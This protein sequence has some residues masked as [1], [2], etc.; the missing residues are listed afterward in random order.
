MV[1][2]AAAAASVRFT[3]LATQILVLPLIVWVAY[4]CCLE[5][6]ESIRIGEAAPANP[7]LLLWPGRLVIVAGLAIL[8]VCA[9]ARLVVLLMPPSSAADATGHGRA[10]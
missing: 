3:E 7:W 4:Q 9:I 8:I 2:E 5:L 1:T 6:L 10:E